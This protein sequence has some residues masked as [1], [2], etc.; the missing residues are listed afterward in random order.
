MWHWERL[1]ITATSTEN[2]LFTASCEITVV[3]STGQVITVSGDI[4]ADTKWY[5]QAKYLLSGF[6]YVKNNATVTIE[7]GTLIKGVVKHKSDTYY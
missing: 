6:V 3:P 1:T 4:T 2:S 5:A 7:A